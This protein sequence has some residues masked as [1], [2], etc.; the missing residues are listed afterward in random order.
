ML[1]ALAAIVPPVFVIVAVVIA[2]IVTL[3]VTIVIPGSSHHASGGQRNQ[4]Q[5]EPAP[6]YGMCI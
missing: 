1:V 4:P 6:K 3:A 2:I 5:H